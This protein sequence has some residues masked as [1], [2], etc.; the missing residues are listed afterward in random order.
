MQIDKGMNPAMKTHTAAAL[1]LSLMICAGLASCADEPNA[2]NE[3]GTPDTAATSDVTDTVTEEIDPL[4]ELDF[5]G[6]EI[7]F[8]ISSFDLNGWG[9][10][11]YLI[12]T[13]EEETGD[14][15]S[16][17]VYKRNH[18]VEDL[19]NV[20]LSFSETDED[21]NSIPSTLSQTIL[22]GDDAYDAVSSFLFPLASMSVEG[23][24]LNAEDGKYFDFS[25]DYW[26][27]EYMSELSFG[28]DGTTYLLSGDMYLDM[29]RSSMCIYFNKDI[30]RDYF[31]DADLLYDVVLDGGWTYDTMLSYVSECY[32]DV[33]GDSTK[34]AGDIY[35]FGYV[36][37]W[38]S[39]Y[40]FE[41]S[42]DLT[43]LSYE[44]DGH[45]VLSLNN[46]RSVGV[47]DFLNELFYHANAYDFGGVTENNNAFKSGNVLFSGCQM[48]ASF[49]SFRDMEAEIGILPYPKYDENQKTYVTPG[50]DV[51]NVGVI[52]NTCQKLDTVSAVLE[53]L[54]RATGDTVLPA[55]YETA[56][57]VKYS[58][59][60]ATSQMLDLIRD[61]VSCVFP[62]AYGNYCENVPLYHAFTDPLVLKS[63]DF[64][65]NYVKWET[66]A[67]AKLD[68]LWDA[69]STLE[70]Q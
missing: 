38:G 1:L 37:K 50:S 39:A 64:V 53:A 51:A 58:R 62:L 7:R 22:A 28:T 19:L 63:T 16:D 56:L 4:A 20:T 69:F 61:G 30:F 45:P 33:N 57:K 8:F 47:L 31:D 52:P 34:D 26:N 42:A 66:K 54:C 41:I 35:G 68:E 11:D 21:W 29:I 32:S 15:V 40:P 13:P 12:E 44:S 18:A 27:R 70:N 10:S 9:P 65:S 43:F 14:V 60:D 48:I 3:T 55:Y 24:F 46:E 36:G 17:A 5:G 49:D 59:D 67:Q 2:G 25:Q 23:Y 6:E